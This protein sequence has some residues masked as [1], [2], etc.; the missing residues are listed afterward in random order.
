MDA[1]LQR[2]IQR[3][4]WDRAAEHYEG[5]WHRQLRPAQDRLVEMAD[6]RPGETVIETSCGSGLVTLRAADGVGPEGRVLATDVSERMVELTRAAAAE[7][8]MS[9]IEAARMGAEKLDVADGAFDAALS[10]LGLMYVPDPDRALAEMHRVLLPGG[11]AVAAVWGARKRCGWAG[12][13]PVVDARVRTE[14]CP[15]FF[16]L[17][18]GDA[19]AAAF[20]LAGFRDVVEERLSTE[21]D[22]GSE[23]AALAA[24]FAGGPVAMAYSRFDEATRRRAHAEYVA[25]IEPYRH[26]DGYRIPG[27]F[28]VVRGC[29][30][31]PE[32]S[33]S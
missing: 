15:L 10:A 22:Y 14:V 18:T 25:T 9:W 27:E 3:Y 2:R 7:R 17:G 21:L 8:E 12:I 29:K 28:V 26:G 30:P 4:G 6:L 20:R 11:R 1:A 23:D 13:F 16:A 31:D 19:L 24:A 5:S 33:S 32:S